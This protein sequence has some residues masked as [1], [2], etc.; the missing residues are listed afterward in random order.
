VPKNYK[1]VAVPLFELYDNPA[2]FGPILSSLP[3]ML[4][5]FRLNIVGGSAAAKAA[6]AAAA[7]VQ[8]Q[9]AAA[10]AAVQQQQAVAIGGGGYPQ[11][12]MET[13]GYY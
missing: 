3:Q 7:G 2:R 4:C 8:Q 13:D 10:A 12:L 9:A 11:Q 5:R 6:A 1:L